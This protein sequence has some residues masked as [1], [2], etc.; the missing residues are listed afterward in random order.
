MYV[1]SFY[2]F[3]GGVG[4]TVGML[5]TG[6][7]LASRGR[8]VML[9]D[10]DLEAPGLGSARLRRSKRRTHWIPAQQKAGFCELVQA[11][12]ESGKFP[13]K[14]YKRNLCDG[15]GPGKRM[16]LMAAA[17]AKA[18]GKLADFVQTFSWSAFYLEENGRSFM[19]ALVEGFTL[20]GFDY[21]L[22]DAR[23]GLTDVAG[24][25]LLHL[26]DLAVFFTN[27][28]QQSVEG[29]AARIEDIREVNDK[30]LTAAGSKSRR[31]NA[32]HQPID[33][34]VVGSPLPTGEWRSRQDRIRKIEEHL[35][36]RLAVQVD[37]LPLLALDEGHHI[38]VQHLPDE[39][40]NVD[41]LLLGATR[42]F[43][44]LAQ[45]IAQRNPEDPDNLVAQ[46]H[47]LF[48][49]GLW[50]DALTHFGEVLDR[51]SET[52]DDLTRGS[53][54]EARFHRIPAQL[55]G[56]DA[57]LAA[58]DLDKLHDEL[59]RE[60]RLEVNAL[61]L[62]QVWL[63]V[64][65]TS[66]LIS[67]FRLAAEAAE[68]AKSLIDELK[69]PDRSDLQAKSLKALA[70]LRLG[71]AR[72][73][74]G[75]WSTA[76]DTLSAA[77]AEYDSLRTRPLLHCRCL[78]ELAQTRMMIGQNLEKEVAPFLKRARRIADAQES[79]SGK[80]TSDLVRAHLH[81]AQANLLTEQ[82]R[83]DEA[84]VK[85]SEARK[86]FSED[87]DDVGQTDVVLAWTALGLKPEQFERDDAD[88]GKDWAHWQRTADEQLRMPRVA[89]RLKLRQLAWKLALGE[90]GSKDA[91]KALLAQIENGLVKAQDPAFPALVRL[92]YCRYLLLDGDRLGDAEQ[93]LAK[94]EEAQSVTGVREE[95]E[96]DLRI[97]NALYLLARGNSSNET[98]KLQAHAD[99]LRARGY[100]LREAQARFALAMLNGADP[101]DAVIGRLQAPADWFWNFPLLFL[102]RSTID[103]LRV[104]YQ[105]LIKQLGPQW[106]MESP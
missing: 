24:I 3:K 29:V 35:G 92:E 73:L 5:N 45:E 77:E 95:T 65:Y 97:L 87:R 72:G 58:E 59:K 11:F 104:P 68:K 102:G 53:A 106:P 56:L 38:L 7:H 9:L 17:G 82:G 31:R 79:T 54:L 34:L 44:R 76:A 61:R 16:A 26:P 47:E 1:V 99:G 90:P 57:K 37:Y 101:G 10:L 15:L 48:E 52:G 2:S 105:R 75:E 98:E 36:C 13:D 70:C 93:Q 91:Y 78:A 30:C 80:L 100:A 66:V 20:L 62:A 4:R 64:S 40:V 43:E 46:G 28:S 88:A 50:R 94:V 25:S 96:H 23:T 84:R 85:L 14:W 22:I 67:E 74:T 42:C 63:A 49:I 55:Q 18:G 19:E 69:E 86:L 8:R 6:W 81:L 71:Y 12:R 89:R 21:L 39:H 60:D 33:T 51:S 103:N 83:G 32:S 27:L 41:E